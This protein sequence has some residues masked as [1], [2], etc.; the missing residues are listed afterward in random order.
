VSQQDFQT[1]LRAA[2]A[3]IVGA[4]KF[5]VFPPVGSVDG[6]WVVVVQEEQEITVTM[7]EVIASAVSDDPRVGVVICC[8]DGSNNYKSLVEV[9]G[10]GATLVRPSTHLEHVV[11]EFW[12][13]QGFAV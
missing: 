10:G 7:L 1:R 13:K 4:N 12:R 2:L 8:V 11:K 6:Y 5:S 3:S 9:S